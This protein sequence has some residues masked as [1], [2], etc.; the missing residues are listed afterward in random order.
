MVVTMGPV[1]S[2]LSISGQVQIVLW[3]TL[4]AVAIFFLIAFLI[5]LCSSCDREKKPR[6]QSGDDENLMNVTSDKEMFSHSVTSLATDAL[7]SSDHNGALTNGD[8]LSEDSTMTCMQHYEEV[9]TSASDLLDSQDS[10]GR[11]SKCHQ[12]RELPRIPPNST[13]DTTVNASSVDGDQSG[14]MEGPYEVLKDSSSQENMVED[15][16]YETVKEIKE[17]GATTHP[18]KGHNGKSKSITTLKEL[19]EPQTQG[20]ME[21]AEYAS[22]D[23]NKKCRQSANSEIVLGSSHDPEEET[24]PP[25]PVK[26]LDEKENLQEKEERPADEEGATEGTTE[27]NKRFSSLSYKSREEDPTLTDEEISA[28]YS[29][30]NKPGQSVNKPGQSVNKS[31]QLLQVPESSYTCIQDGAPQSSP[32]SCNDLYATV[33]E[34][35]K[36]PNSVSTPPP[37]ERPSVEPEPDYEA[38]QTLNREE[39]KATQETN[40]L[41]V[42][43][44]KENDYESIGDLEQCRSIT[45]L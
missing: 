6:P 9:E 4:A 25:V 34:F 2:M 20:K 7:A 10:A 38:I 15:C 35:E 17:V 24:P 26:L 31:A 23:K 42:L 28:M 13:V 30:V 27:I 39:E 19:P 37:A 14:G 44:P 36:A 5:F 43:F 12:S 41:H 3:E 1:G 11:P 45:R 22:V 21:F 40:G 32:S 16:L 18:D 33:K 29:S 8:I